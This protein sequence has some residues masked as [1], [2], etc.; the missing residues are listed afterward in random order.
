M[1]KMWH[2]LFWKCES[3]TGT[4]MLPNKPWKYT[5]GGENM[6]FRKVIIVATEYTEDIIG[7]LLFLLFLTTNIRKLKIRPCHR[8]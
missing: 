2:G 6:I 1:S 5:F 7:N 3:H 4:I 8:K